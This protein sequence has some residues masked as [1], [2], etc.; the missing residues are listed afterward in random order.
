[1]GGVVGVESGFFGGVGVITEA[2]VTICGTVLAVVED[3]DALAQENGWRADLGEAG[4]EMAG[5]LREDCD[6][7]GGWRGLRWASSG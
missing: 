6:G 5:A 7:A 4:V 3:D 2:G 1:M